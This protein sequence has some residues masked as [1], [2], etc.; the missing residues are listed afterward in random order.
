M[1]S[2]R[3]QWIKAAPIAA[4]SAVAAGKASTVQAYEFPSEPLLSFT[5]MGGNEPN[6]NINNN[7]SDYQ[8]WKVYDADGIL[9]L[10]GHL[11]IRVIGLIFENGDPND[12][13][14]F[15]AIFSCTS[16]DSGGNQIV[17]NRSTEDFPTGP[18]GNA[19]IRS[20]VSIPEYCWAPII[21]VGPG[22]GVARNTKI[23]GGAWF[24]STGVVN[25]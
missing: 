2:T 14:F 11:V 20:R 9:T 6:L 1:K 13:N 15:R 7:Q 21:F 8:A 19:L 23:S 16:V 17:I 3:R 10:D 24:A 12:E 25:E 5:S 22:G 4:V 18:A